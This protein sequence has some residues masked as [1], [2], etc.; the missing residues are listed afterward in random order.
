[1][2]RSLRVSIA[3]ALF[4]VAL[5][6]VFGAA[7]QIGITYYLPSSGGEATRHVAVFGPAVTATVVAGLAALALAA[8]L[9]QAIR[10]VLPRWVWIVAALLTVVAV[11]APVVVGGLARPAF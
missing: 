9:V 10:G 6:G 8:H 3:S 7:T 11:A 2:S 1:M 4:V 5:L